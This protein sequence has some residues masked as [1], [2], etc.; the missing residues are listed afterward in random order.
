M[1]YVEIFAVHADGKVVTFG[2]ARNNHAYTPVVWEVLGKKYG[3]LRGGYLLMDPGIADLWRA[4]G[5]GKLT[6]DEDLLLGSTFDRV[7]IRRDA[8]ESLVR[9]LREFY[10]THIKGK[11][12]E[13]VKEAADTIE[14]MTQEIPDLRGVAFNQCSANADS[15]SRKVFEGL[16]DDEERHFSQYDLEL[17][18]INKFGAQYLALQSVEGNKGAPGGAA[19][20]SRPTLEAASMKAG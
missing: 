11:Y 16:V 17:E 12:A 15:G 9:V 8:L 3:F 7:W 10:E 20:V 1:S 14:R 13:T 4:L 18:K 2:H 19:S 5:T 6:P